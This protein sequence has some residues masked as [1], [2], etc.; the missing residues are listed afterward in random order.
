VGP[1][2]TRN[3][4]TLGLG[5]GANTAFTLLHASL[6]RPL[7]VSDPKEIFVAMIQQQRELEDRRGLRFSIEVVGV[8]VDH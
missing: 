5:I 1:N 8:S 4:L 3:I 7:A 6:W 2:G